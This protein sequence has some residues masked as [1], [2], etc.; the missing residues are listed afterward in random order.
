MQQ[1]KKSAEEVLEGAELAPAQS[2]WTTEASGSVQLRIDELCPEQPITVHQM[3]TRSVKKYGNLP[4]LATKK[5][6]KWEK[7]TFSEYYSLCRMAAKSF[8]K[9]IWMMKPLTIHALRSN[10]QILLI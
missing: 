9:V 2:L 4:A 5:G 1:S 7:I 8:L 6:N 3:F 10:L